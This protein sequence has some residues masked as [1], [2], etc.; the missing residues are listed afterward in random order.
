MRAHDDAEIVRPP[1]PMK[2]MKRELSN[3]PTNQSCEAS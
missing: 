2:A 1:M 3:Q